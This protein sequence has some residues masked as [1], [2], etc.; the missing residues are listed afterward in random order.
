MAVVIPSVI[1]LQAEL[2]SP[3]SSL[4]NFSVTHGQ[5]LLQE[6]SEGFLS[7]AWALLFGYGTIPKYHLAE[8]CLFP[9]SW[10]HENWRNTL[11]KCFAELSVSYCVF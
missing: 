6:T 3:G 11:V 1:P 5:N 4:L 9:M 2:G 10:F 8:K 7:L